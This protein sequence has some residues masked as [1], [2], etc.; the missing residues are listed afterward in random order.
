MLWIELRSRGV[1]LLLAF[2]D[3]LS[4]HEHLSC[5]LASDLVEVEHELLTRGL[6]LVYP[7]HRCI[8]PKPTGCSVGFCVRFLEGKVHHVSQEIPNPQLPSISLGP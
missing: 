7:L 6:I 4:V 1:L 3:Q 5:S 2:F 8:L